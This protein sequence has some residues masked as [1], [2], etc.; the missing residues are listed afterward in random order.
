MLTHH[1]HDGRAPG[2]TGQ[3]IEHFALLMGGASLPPLADA[4]IQVRA[5]VK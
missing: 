1:G 5:A 3:Y 4:L 2:A